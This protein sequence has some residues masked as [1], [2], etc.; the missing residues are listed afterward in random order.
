MAET[1]WRARSD[2][3]IVD[4]CKYA[5]ARKM[6]NL[7][8]YYKYCM[9]GFGTLAWETLRYTML[10]RLACIW[11]N[12]SPVIRF[13]CSLLPHNS[14]EQHAVWF[15]NEHNLIVSETLLWKIMR[16]ALGLFADALSG[17]P[18]LRNTLMMWAG[19][20]LIAASA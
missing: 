13:A 7:K 9:V 3:D 18:V 5:Y 17:I 16:D 1:K 2:L 8:Y 12:L 14:L 20:M 11:F 4:R 15:A 19:M 6:R 10:F